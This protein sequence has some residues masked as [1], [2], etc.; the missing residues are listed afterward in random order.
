MDCNECR[1]LLGGFAAGELQDAQAAEVRAHADG[2]PECAREVD[3]SAAALAALKAAG[4][5]VP[6]AD[7]AFLRRV[8]KSL[9]EVDLRLGRKSEPLFRWHFVGGVAAAAAAILVVATVLLPQ[10]WQG[11]AEEPQPAQP[12]AG[13]GSPEPPGAKPYLVVTPLEYRPVFSSPGENG[14]MP[15]AGMRALAFQVGPAGGN[16]WP[17]DY[18]RREDYRRLE[19]RV[20][21]LNATVEELR[22]KLTALEGAASPERT[23]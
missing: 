4:E 9:D 11:P 16:I 6:R 3:R 2:C 17:D 19:T 18:V 15:A 13:A 20:R 14:L 22:R 21:Q 8:K 12:V 10:V 23:E 5:T 7:R 1:D